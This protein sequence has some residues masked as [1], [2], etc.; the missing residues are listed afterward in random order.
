ML[1]EV[2]DAE[3]HIIYCDNSGGL[4][5]GPSDWDIRVALKVDPE[6][7]LLWTDGMKKLIPG[8][9]DIDLWDELK[10]ERLTWEEREWAEYWKRPGANTYLVVYP[11]TGIILKIASTMHKPKPAEITYEDEVL[12]F[13]EYKTFASC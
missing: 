13:G 1:S 6:D 5:P 3:Y 8:Q 9:I 12:G 7:I 10:T 4:V 2:K 11:E